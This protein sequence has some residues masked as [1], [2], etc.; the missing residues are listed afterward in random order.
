M[1]RSECEHGQLRRS[2]EICEMRAELV[3]LR[4][5]IH[6]A[7]GVADLAMKHRDAAESKLVELC[8][9]IESA[10]VAEVSLDERGYPTISC[11]FEEGKRVRL[12][13]EGGE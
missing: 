2:C 5:S 9:R 7:N 13:V 3:E 10:P 1:T 6:Y 11:D 8:Q 12:V 4:E